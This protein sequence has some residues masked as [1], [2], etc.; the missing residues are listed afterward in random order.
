MLVSRSREYVY[1]LGRAR[2]RISTRIAMNMRLRERRNS[3][4]GTGYRG[5]SPLVMVQF[6]NRA[7]NLIA[8]LKENLLHAYTFVWYIRLLCCRLCLVTRMNLPISLQREWTQ[9]KDR[10]R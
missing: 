7:R 3:I 10:K 9:A 2:A 5:K 1:T 6:R 4:V 8:N